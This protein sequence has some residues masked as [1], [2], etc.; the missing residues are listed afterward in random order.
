M[1]KKWRQWAICAVVAIGSALGA[2]SLRKISFFEVLNLKAYDA[3][4]IVR[5]YLFSAPS[6]SNIILITA[7]Q[8]AMDRFPELRMLWNKHYA[9]AITAAEEAGAKVIGLDLAFGYQQQYVCVHV[10]HLQLALTWTIE[11]LAIA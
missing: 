10:L 1:T 4:F 11:P 8:T 9:D 5:D 2:W 3:H 6:I 7:D